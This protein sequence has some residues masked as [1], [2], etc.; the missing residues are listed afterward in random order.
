MHE[1]V[2]EL[3]NNFSRTIVKDEAV[4]RFHPNNINNKE[5]W[6]R[7]HKSFPLLSV[8][9]GN[10]KNIKQVNQITLKLSNDFHLFP[11]LENL[12]NTSN[13]KLN[14]LEIGFGFGNV[15]NEVKGKC[16]YIGI[17]YRIPKSLK[18]YKN[19]I[20]INE[21]GIPDYLQGENIFD[22][23]YCVNV[24]QHCS[25]KDRF[26]YF[27]QGYAALKKGGYFIF[28]CLLMT[29]SNQDKYYWGIKDTKGRGYL[30]FFNQLTEADYEYELFNHLHSLGFKSV[31]GWLMDN[32]LAMIIT[33]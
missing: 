13:T 7:A 12:I 3:E 26:E 5:F 20:E 6:L 21:S 11:F 4:T 29:K 18:K 19:F 31:D 9:G 2:V 30:H 16:E 15:F 28:S 24:L 27:K 10:C 8:C 22:V 33:K 23:I 25:Q 1:N 14:V 17:D 32:H